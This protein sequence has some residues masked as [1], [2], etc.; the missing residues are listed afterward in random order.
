MQ[1]H[2]EGPQQNYKHILGICS[3]YPVIHHY[4]FLFSVEIMTCKGK[5]GLYN[6]GKKI[7]QTTDYVFFISAQ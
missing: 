3:L 2:P 5:L 4:A 1:G 6:K 7:L